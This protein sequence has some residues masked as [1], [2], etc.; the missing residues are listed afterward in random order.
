MSDTRT[1][2]PEQ[3]RVLRE[4]ATERARLQPAEL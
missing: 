4:H 2:T 3:H 1:L